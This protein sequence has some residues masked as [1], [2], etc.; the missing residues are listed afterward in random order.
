[1]GWLKEQM[2]RRE[3]PLRS[4]AH[5]AES[6][7]SHP[8]WPDSAR[9][10]PRS[11]ATLFSKIDRGQELD[12]LRDRPTVARVLAQVLDRPLSELQT[13]WGERPEQ[14]QEKIFRF[15]DLRYARDLDLLGESLPPGLPRELEHPAEWSPLLWQVGP[16]GGRSLVASWLRARRLASIC[17]LTHD[18]RQVDIPRQ[19]P[20]FVDARAKLNDELLTSLRLEARPVCIAIDHHYLL[21]IIPRARIINSPSLESYLYELVHWVSLR[22]TPDHRFDEERAAAWIA[23]MSRALDDSTNFGDVIGLLGAFDE[24]GPR[25]LSGKTLRQVLIKM[26]EHRLAEAEL[27]PRVDPEQALQRLEEAA[28]RALVSKSGSLDRPRPID[29]WV[30]LLR[31]EQEEAEGPDPAWFK[32]ALKK[33]GLSRDELRRIT[34]N[35]P[36]SL[37]HMV[38]AL[39]SIGVLGRAN[40]D[41]KYEDNFRKLRPSYLAHFLR[42]QAKS[43]IL[44]LSPHHWGFCTLDR[45]L[46]SDIIL[47]LTRRVEDDDLQAHE[48]L[49]DCFDASSLELWAALE[50]CI[51]S[52]GLASLAGTPVPEELALELLREF[53]PSQPSSSGHFLA[54]I[55]RV[56]S[57]SVAVLALTETLPNVSANI[58]PWRTDDLD[59]R[60]HFVRDAIEFAAGSEE[61]ERRAAIW[62][63]LLRFADSTEESSR[64]RI[65]AAH[66]LLR[67]LDQLR[68]TQR[69]YSATQFVEHH[70]ART[71]LAVAL[72]IGIPMA[73][74]SAQILDE[75][76]RL[77][78]ERARVTLKRFRAEPN[79]TTTELFR[80]ALA[81]RLLELAER[82][83]PLPYGEL[84]PHQLDHLSFA[85]QRP[86][87]LELAECTPAPSALSRLERLGTE[88]FDDNALLVLIDRFPQSFGRACMS[89]AFDANGARPDLIVKSSRFLELFL[90][91]APALEPLE[92]SLE[93]R[94]LVRRALRD[95]LAAE[96][97]E[98]QYAAYDALSAFE[99]RL[100]R[101]SSPSRAALVRPGGGLDPSN[102]S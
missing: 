64:D 53:A 61:L 69:S 41:P 93:V 46:S 45:C 88:G 74:L 17:T 10:R 65:I 37:Y 66:P 34:Q 85:L 42:A 32:D 100:A 91:T 4:F 6:C 31:S 76:A 38:K 86:L 50:A 58:S 26:L 16:G 81:P 80:M 21:P 43:E 79:A 71:L 3:P 54:R 75:L 51:E 67:C 2:L 49:I 30:M 96:K 55:R 89:R 18:A 7:Q 68:S 94:A 70:G 39:E 47:R 23:R 92:L 20:L 82:S 60:L 78:D 95:A 97:G 56:N 13:A 22:L 15:R 52:L 24:F 63:L 73:H 101:D 62:T 87:P 84:L 44:K 1:M 99:S 12:W 77:P 9:L 98:R 5:L 72:A 11:L 29:E 48:A 27:R 28:A 25:T 40:P 14:R 90:D 33:S 57:F 83:L 19:G 35:L 8:E 59:F 102:S 36:P